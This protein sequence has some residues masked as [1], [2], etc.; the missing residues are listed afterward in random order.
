MGI[1]VREDFADVQC[2]VPVTAVGFPP[3]G[4][5]FITACLE[6]AR[7]WDLKGKILGKSMNHPGEVTALAFYQGGRILLT[8]CKDNKVRGWDLL[9]RANM[10]SSITKC[11]SA[12][13]R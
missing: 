10:N 5:A 3:A 12:A 1:A 11:P 9:R 4:T 13:W 8:A 2:V 6:S 7:R